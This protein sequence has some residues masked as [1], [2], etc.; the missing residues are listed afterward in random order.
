M[1]KAVGWCRCPPEALELYRNT[2]TIFQFLSSQNMV[3][4]SSPAQQTVPDIFGNVGFRI[5]L[6]L[7]PQSNDL[8]LIKECPCLAS[9]MPEKQTAFPVSLE[10]LYF[11]WNKS[12]VFIHNKTSQPRS[13]MVKS[14][15]YFSS[16]GMRMSKASQSQSKLSS[17]YVPTP[18]PA[19]KGQ[20]EKAL[21]W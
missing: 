7:A 13:S 11:Q 1:L 14:R 12:I 18:V 2:E 21:A 4:F 5:A 19:A 15:E 17:Y 16:A 9:Q 20:T 3:I 8:H 6:Q 10:L